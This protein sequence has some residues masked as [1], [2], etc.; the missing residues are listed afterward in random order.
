M[1]RAAPNRLEPWL[2][3]ILSAVLFGISHFAFLSDPH[4]VQNDVRQQIYWMEQYRDSGLFQDHLLTEYARLY[5]PPGVKA[6]YRFFSPVISPLY[7][8]KIVPGPEYIMMAVCLFLIGL[9]YGGR[10]LGWA[11][12]AVFWISPFFISSMGGGLARSFGPP[13]LCLLWLAWLRGW[14]WLAGASLVFMALCIPYIFVLSA[15]ALGL[16]WLTIPLSRFTRLKERRPPFPAG[17]LHWAVLL[18]CA[19]LVFYLNHQ[20]T[21]AGFGPWVSASEAARMPELGSGGRLEVFPIHSLPWELTI[22]AW[23]RIAPFRELD[24]WGGGIVCGLMIL[25]ALAGLWKERGYRRAG[26]SGYRFGANLEPVFFLGLAGAVLHTV[27]TIL[28]FRLFMPD[29]FVIYQLH[30]FYV[31]ALAMAALSLVRPWL[32]KPRWPVALLALALVVGLARSYHQGLNDYRKLIP[33]YQAVRALPK[34]ARLAGHP[35]TM[36]NVQTF[37]QRPV[38]IN[39]EQAHPWSKG[40]WKEEDRRLRD[41]FAAYYS[42]APEPIRDFC[43]RYRLTHLVVE[44]NKY[45]P[46]FMER[47][48]FFAPYDQL[49]RNLAGPARGFALLR[50]G[51]GRRTRVAPGIWLVDVRSETD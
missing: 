34:E 8:T 51:F 40:L 15:G 48:G 9:E 25:A 5:V 46:R 7:L 28:A 3:A 23:A 26:E 45:E 20:L 6:L 36:D 33:V 4:I 1:E 50:E 41:L 42:P 19:G 18:A 31:L 38:L 30:L 49:I 29:R 43:R 13:L 27:A 17:F 12:V 16:A 39:Y 24:P 44:E 2:V 14:G 32:E 22:G 35:S 21:K 10:R 37:G 11:C 47:G